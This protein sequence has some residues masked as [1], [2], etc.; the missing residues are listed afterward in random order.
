[1][2]RRITLLLL[3][4]ACC[5]P[6]VVCAQQ[7]VTTRLQEI[8]A[9]ESTAA[10]AAQQDN[11]VIED[12]ACRWS[13]VLPDGSRL[14]GRTVLVF[15]GDIL[16][17]GRM[18]RNIAQ[19]GIDYPFS[20]VADVLRG[21]DFACGN[22]ESP[23]TS[24][25]QPTAGKSA[26]SI[27]A[28]QN[29][30]FKA[31]PEYATPALCSAGYDCLVLANNH[32]MDYRAAGLLDTLGA[33]EGADLACC[34]GGRDAMQAAQGCVVQAGGLRIGML[35]YS[36]IVPAASR[37]GGAS[38][39]I[40]ALSKRFEPALRDSIARLRQQADVVVVACHWGKEGSRTPAVYQREIAHA[41]ID[42]GATLVIGSHPHVMQGVELYH[43]GAI[44]YS[45]GNFV[46]CGAAA[47]VESAVLRVEL[48]G[49]HVARVE[50]M[51]LW[52]KQGQPQPAGDER[53][54]R[55]LRQICSSTGTRLTAGD[56]GWL[57]V[58]SK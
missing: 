41:C 15:T 28:R 54:L 22:L 9:D 56:D 12:T 55:L 6:V 36:L 35:A 40:N 53:L 17:A 39:G 8:T 57:W 19:Y 48:D 16:L 51:P 37:A 31:P 1:M 47:Q 46:F 4:I 23:V 24:Q 32:A 49:T 27:R 7:P 20:Q 45:L 11:A 52:V 30:I 50:L 14:P 43:G 38:P 34:G 42:A 2:P 18:A 5:L 3:L 33:L 21:A 10:A 13:E 25:A 26:A 44:A 29:F 58:E